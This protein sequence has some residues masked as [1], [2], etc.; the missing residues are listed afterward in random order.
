M[1]SQ[2][3]QVADPPIPKKRPVS[4]V[5]EFQGER[6]L[7]RISIAAL[8]TLMVACVISPRSFAQRV[9]SMETVEPLRLTV[10]PNVSS[11]ISM[12]TFPEATCKLHAEDAAPTDS[13]LKLFADDEGVVRFHV[14]PE[15]ESEQAV[16]FEVDCTAGKVAKRFPL[17]LRSNSASTLDMPAPAA[18]IKKAEREALVRP[19]LSNEDALRLDDNELARRGYP[20]R[21]DPAQSPSAFASWLRAVSQSVKLVSARSVVNPERKH[22]VPRMTSNSSVSACSLSDAQCYFSGAQLLLSPLAPGFYDTTASYWWVPTIEGFSNRVHYTASALWVGLSAVHSYG[23]QVLWQ[24]GTDQDSFEYLDLPLVFRFTS[25]YAWTDFPTTFDEVPEQQYPSL[26]VNPGDLIYTAVWIGNSTAEVPSLTGSYGVAYMQNLTQGCA[27]NPMWYRP[28]LD[29]ATVAEYGTQY[30]A[31]LAYWIMERPAHC[32]TPTDPSTCGSYNLTDYGQAY[33]WGSIAHRTVPN[34][35]QAF[36][37]TPSDL[38]S[39]SW[40]FN[41]VDSDFYND[42][43]STASSNY[44]FV[45]QGRFAYLEPGIA[46]TWI[47]FY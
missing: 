39:S 2:F 30:P 18:E 20:P 22:N 40:V 29:A 34:E 9:Q 12:N 3:E 15:S 23:Y 32:S 10:A 16:Q 42:L 47:N 6:V 14:R 43:L 7:K 19:A 33:M 37:A 4:S 27:I 13:G 1:K 38:Y 28:D 36:D 26:P 45:I 24:A 35:W 21:P 25:Y 17:H 44:M 11:L 46:F 31:D 8:A 41:M 5:K